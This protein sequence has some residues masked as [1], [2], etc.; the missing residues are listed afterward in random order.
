MS[1]IKILVN[2][3]INVISIYFCVVY[4]E[5]ILKEELFYWILRKLRMTIDVK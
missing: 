1:G 4:K 2:M 3:S 5:L